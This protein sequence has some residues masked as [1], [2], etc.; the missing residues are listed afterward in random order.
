MSENAAEPKDEELAYLRDELEAH[1]K[2]IKLLNSYLRA[3][4][5]LKQALPLVKALE[6]RTQK[7]DDPNYMQALLQKGI[8]Q[9]PLY[10]WSRAVITGFVLLGVVV[11]VGAMLYSGQQISAIQAQ[12]AAVSRQSENFLGSVDERL[13]EA[14][15][16]AIGSTRRAAQQAADLKQAAEWHVRSIEENLSAAKSD[17]RVIA[18]AREDLS[19]VVGEAGSLFD[20]LQDMKRSAA[21]GAGLR[22]LGPIAGVEP[23]AR[24]DPAAE[25][26][27][28]RNLG[29]R[30]DGS[31]LAVAGGLGAVALIAGLL[32]IA[33]ALRGIA[34][35]AR[36][37]PAS[38]QVHWGHAKRRS[39]QATERDDLAAKARRAMALPR[40]ANGW[41]SPGGGDFR[42][43]GS[44]P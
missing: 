2:Q 36:S 24:V 3:L 13:K 10:K 42:P 43:T 41:A 5:E 14:T 29:E 8:L 19:R 21:D 18:S 16:V 38:A 39:R 15:E 7:F 32:L 22:P 35:W 26:I 40:P 4:D 31:L 44:K 27:T 30:L 33:Q 9:T 12:A 34:G 6:F 1:K 25:K 37:K 23:A 20:T 17:A 11:W 28:I